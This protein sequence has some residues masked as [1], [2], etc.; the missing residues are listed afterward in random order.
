MTLPGQYG[1]AFVAAAPG[2]FEDPAI[3]RFIEESLVLP[4]RESGRRLQRSGADA[5]GRAKRPGAY[6]GVRR[7]R[8]LARRR[9]STR[10]PALV[11]MRARKPW[12]RA[13]FILLG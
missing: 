3:V 9:L 11:A 2:F 8:P 1:K 12:V 13:R 10:R 6:W 4:E 7:A 5:R